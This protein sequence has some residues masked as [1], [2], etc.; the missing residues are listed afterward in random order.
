MRVSLD[1]ELGTIGENAVISALWSRFPTADGE[2]PDNDCAIVGPEAN[3]DTLTTVDMQ[4]EDQDFLMRYSTPYDVG[5]KSAAMNLSDIGACGGTPTSLYIAL[6]MPRHRSVRDLVAF[7]DG[8]REACA[9]CAPGTMVRGGDMSDA[10]RIVVSITAVGTVPSGRAVPRDG[11]RPGDQ[12]CYAGR[13]GQARAGITA[14]LQDAT[15][16]ATPEALEAQLRPRPPV[17]LGAR[18][19]ELGVHAMLD[20][21]DGLAID[22]E[23]M[24]SASNITI[25]YDS[26]A[27]APM[28]ADLGW[29]RHALGADPW[30]LVMAGGE[31]YGLLAAF[32]P[33]AAVPDEFL[34]VGTALPA[35]EHRVLLAGEPSRYRGWDH[36]ADSGQDP[37]PA[38]RPRH[39]HSA[40]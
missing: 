28:A 14:M 13:L 34:R 12:I 36:Y 5:W 15:D 35:G 33:D 21:S 11:A 30:A 4:L 40:A 27:L 29:A 25:D 23:R 32:P 38:D 10:E 31:D 16:Q 19:R 9:A 17:P 37:R 3:L 22:G 6:A 20:V 26:A 18:A 39:R 1:A 24:A 2:L 8:V 7:A